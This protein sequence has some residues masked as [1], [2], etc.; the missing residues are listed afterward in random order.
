L[1]YFELAGK[2]GDPDAA[3]EAGALWAAGKGCKK[4]LKKAAAFYRMAVSCRDVGFRTREFLIVNEANLSH[5]H[6]SQQIEAG[7]DGVGLSWV[8]KPKW[9]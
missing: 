8:Y 4:D 3:A 1:E 7:Y 9:Q 5:A 6:L 2:L